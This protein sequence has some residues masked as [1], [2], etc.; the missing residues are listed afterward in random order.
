MLIKTTLYLV[1]LSL[2]TSCLLGTQPSRN[3]SVW[4]TAVC[5]SPEILQQAYEMEGNFLC[6]D[7]GETF[8][9]KLG[10]TCLDEVLNNSAGM[11]SPS[12]ITEIYMKYLP[13]KECT[14]Q[15]IDYFSSSK[16]KPVIY[17][18]KSPDKTTKPKLRRQKF[19]LKLW[20]ELD[21]IGQ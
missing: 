19:K 14:D 11:D 16:Y 9:I 5:N 10:N 6:T 18:G 15:L 13:D 8:N 7:L 20:T 12:E 2:T 17:H 3:R 4:N 1:L 21:T